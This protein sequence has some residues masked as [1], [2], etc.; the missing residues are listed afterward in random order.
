MVELRKS[1]P[2]LAGQD[3]ELIAIPNS[4]LLG[5]VR[6]C[7]GN[8]LLLLA[9]FSEQSQTVEGNIVRTAGLGRFFRDLLSDTTYSTATPLTLAPYQSLWFERA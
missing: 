3:M 9:N 6:M 1:L 2:A 4:H 7:E 5:F 8:R